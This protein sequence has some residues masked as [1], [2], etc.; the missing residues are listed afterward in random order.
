MKVPL[1]DLH[2]SYR[3]LKAEID[4]AVMEVLESQGFIMGPKVKALEEAIAQYVGAPHAIAC[5]SGSDALLLALMALDLGPGDEVITTPYSFFATAGSIARLGATP[6]FVDI[7]LDTFNLNVDAI[8][9]AITPRTKA[10]MPVHLFGQCPDMDKL[11]AIADKHNLPVVEDAAQAIGSRWR[12]GSA[13]TFGSFGCFSFYPSKNLGAYGDGGIIT[14]K[15]PKLDTKLRAL[16]THGGIKKYYHQ[17]VGMNSRLDAMQAAILLVRLKHLDAWHAARQHNA[18]RYYALFTQ[19]GLDG[20]I[21]LPTQNPRAFHIYNQFVIRGPERDGLQSYLKEKGVGSEVY[22]PLSLH[23]QPC[24]ENLGYKT[25]DFPNA[26]Q[27]ASDS[28]AIPIYPEL[29]DEQ[30]A[31]VV[32]TIAAFYREKGL[33]K[34][35]VPGA[36]APEAGSA[37]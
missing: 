14:V 8:E 11:M 7:D 16:R 13:G 35:E 1:L 17:Y 22:Y 34:P 31:Y 33:L 10:I 27:A 24:F 9:A 18:C 4:A 15:D 2:A 30:K 37:A 6:V 5:A 21:T 3:P 12:N 28:L 23:Q 32:Q 19:A 20:L 26:E 29:T 25:G 36:S